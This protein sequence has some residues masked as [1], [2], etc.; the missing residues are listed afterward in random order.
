MKITRRALLKSSALS[1]VVAT[2]SGCERMVTQAGQWLGEAVPEKIELSAGALID[3]DFHLLSRAGFGPRPGDLRY[4][5]SIG[6]DAWLEEQLHPQTIED[7]ACDLRAERFESLSFPPGTLMN[8][9]N[10]YCGLN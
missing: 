4:L 1:G 3:L 9:G 5:R 8:S 2:L 6:R 10:Q 7:T